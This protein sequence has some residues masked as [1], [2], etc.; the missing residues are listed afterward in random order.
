MR[1]AKNPPQLGDEGLV[2]SPVDL[3]E[4]RGDEWLEV[5]ARPALD[6][7]EG[8]GER[9][10]WTVGTV[11]GQGVEEVGDCNYP[12]LEGDTLSSSP[13]RISGAVPP[14]MV[15]ERDSLGHADEL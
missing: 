9:P 7:L 3:G 15:T 4:G 1:K 8:F 6:L 5:R 10:G 12:G 11:V 13:V 14:L 2:G